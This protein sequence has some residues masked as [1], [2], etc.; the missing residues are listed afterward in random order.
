MQKNRATYLGLTALSLLATCIST[1]GCAGER[2]EKKD[3]PKPVPLEVAKVWRDAGAKVGWMQ[4]DRNG[5]LALCR[6]GTASRAT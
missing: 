4:Q 3:D 1:C 6:R 2:S 5:I